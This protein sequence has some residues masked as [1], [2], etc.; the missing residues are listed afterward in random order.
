MAK[1]ID[2]EMKKTIQIIIQYANFVSITCGEVTSMDIA[3]WASTR[4]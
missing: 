4:A 3:S 1:H 2:N